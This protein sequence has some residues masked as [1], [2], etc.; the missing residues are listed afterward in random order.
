MCGA[1]PTLPHAFIMVSYLTKHR[2]D[3][4]S[5]YPGSVHTLP[6]DLKLDCSI[7]VTNHLN[8]ILGL[9]RDAFSSSDCIFVASN[10][11]LISE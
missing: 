11:G 3:L 9:F 6:T 1:I 4:P 8:I 5:P 7:M 10:D 2:D